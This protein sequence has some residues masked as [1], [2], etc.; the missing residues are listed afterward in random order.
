MYESDAFQKLNKQQV[1][2]L[3]VYVLLVDYK[4]HHFWSYMIDRFHS[5]VWFLFTQVFLLNMM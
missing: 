1:T 3:S 2:E 4:N 5:C